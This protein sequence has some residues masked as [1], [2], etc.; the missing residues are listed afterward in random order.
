M[1]PFYILIASIS[2]NFIYMCSK[3][4]VVAVQQFYSIRKI[5]RKEKATTIQFHFKLVTT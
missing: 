4:N 5:T 1:S 3:N 2:C